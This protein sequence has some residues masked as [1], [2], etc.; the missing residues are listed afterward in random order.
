[1]T[2]H[3][4]GPVPSRRLG[5]SLGVDVTPRKYCSYDCV[6]CQ[7]GPTTHKTIERSRFFDPQAIV[8]EIIN[9]TAAAQ[10]VDCVTFSGSGEPTLNMDLEEMIKEVK[11]RINKPVAVITNG[12]LLFLDEVRRG[13]LLAD[14]I[15]PS[16]DAATVK[17][18]LQVNKPHQDLDLN[19]ILKGFK[20]LRD[21]FKGRILLEIMLIRGINDNEQELKSLRQV[22]LDLNVDKIQLNTVV[23]PP[24]QREIRRVGEGRLHGIRDLFGERC[25]VICSFGKE[26]PLQGDNDWAEMVL[27][28]IGRRSLSLSDIVRITGN[29]PE[30]AKRRLTELERFGK[31]K[32]YHFEDNVF[33]VAQE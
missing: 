28:I 8:G 11:R 7:V 14:V 32:S 24:A 30:D 25:E 33:Y 26:I 3:V 4:F 23:R 19:E 2:H 22:A 17:V 12:S 18:F 1:M 31:L 27:E 20:R 29:S 21:D 16:L 5:F 10:R 13:L 9:K 15:L 6:Y